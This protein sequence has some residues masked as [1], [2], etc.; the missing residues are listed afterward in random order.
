MFRWGVRLIRIVERKTGNEI[1]YEIWIINGETKVL[2]STIHYRAVCREIV[3]HRW[4]I[5]YDSNM[6]PV[7]EA[8]EFLNYTCAQQSDNSRIK[9][10]QALKLIYSLCKIIGKDFSKISTVD[11]NN[12]KTFMK[13]ITLPGSEISMELTTQRSNRTVNGYLSVFRGYLLSLKIKNEA[14]MRMSRGDAWYMQNSDR[15]LWYQISEHLP[16]QSIEVPSYISVEEFVRILKII[17]EK[18]GPREECIVRLMYQNGLRLGEVLGL[19]N[20][21]LVEEKIDG[22]W[23]PV[24]YIRNR[25]SDKPFQKAKTCMNIV[26]K[27]QYLTKDYQEYGFQK[28]ILEEEL[29]QLLI[30]YM[31]EIHAYAAENWF[32]IY[33]KGSLADRVRKEEP[34][35]EKNRY[36]FISHYG[37]PLRADSWNIVLRKIFDD[38]KIIV[39]S[40]VRKHNLNHRFRHGFAMY[41]VQYMGRNE[42]ELMHLMRHSSLKSVETYFKPTLE[43]QLS[44]KQEFEASLRSSI[45]ALNYKQEV[46][47]P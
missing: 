25:I 30:K 5:L 32:T 34:F 47:E 31:C 36:A 33:D 8:F 4:L 44:L 24:A 3:G 35:E 43:D 11:T 14:L 41:Q 38:A 19:T 37:R 17:R 12:L 26:D 10:L 15:H 9:S 29:Y 13:G 16:I 39:D 22:C 1:F 28:V 42:L 20:D 46:Q 2:T 45:P 27:K 6:V 40:Q 7:T 21:D 18:Y 23:V